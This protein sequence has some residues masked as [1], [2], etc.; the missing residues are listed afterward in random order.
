MAT[1]L[2]P[3]IELRAPTPDDAEELGRICFDAFR[4]IAERRNFPPDFPRAGGGRWIALHADLASKY[5][6]GR[7]A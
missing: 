4:S 7:S 2:D 3:T 5:L 1:R 6:R